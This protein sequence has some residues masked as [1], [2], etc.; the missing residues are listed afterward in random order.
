MIISVFEFSHNLVITGY[1]SK[2]ILPYK[3]DIVNASGETGTM[4][5]DV[6]HVPNTYRG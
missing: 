6:L 4:F 1:T 2:D 5:I 3:K